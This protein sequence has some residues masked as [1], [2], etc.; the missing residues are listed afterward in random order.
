[1]CV[2]KKVLSVMDTNEAREKDRK[3]PGRNK[4]PFT[5]SQRVV[6]KGPT[7]KVTHRQNHKASEKMSH[8]EIR[9]TRRK[10]LKGREHGYP[11]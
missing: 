3:F 6:V 2:Y 10:D 7:E 5:A 8:M 4:S 9:G 1:M 11:T